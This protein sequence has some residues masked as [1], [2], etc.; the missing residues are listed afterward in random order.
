MGHQRN[1]SL[2]IQRLRF[3]TAVRLSSLIEFLVVIAIIAILAT[4]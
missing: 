4:L 3:A 1:A 2:W